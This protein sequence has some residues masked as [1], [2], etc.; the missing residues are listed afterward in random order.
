MKRYE[1]SLSELHETNRPQPMNILLLIE[2]SFSLSVGD[3]FSTKVHAHL[4]VCQFSELKRKRHTFKR[5]NASNLCSGDSFSGGCEHRFFAARCLNNTCSFKFKVFK[6]P[7]LIWEATILVPHSCPFEEISSPF[8]YLLHMFSDIGL[9][10]DTSVI[11]SVNFR[12]LQWHLNLT[13]ETTTK[14]IPAGVKSAA[15]IHPSCKER[16]TKF[17]DTRSI[18]Q[19]IA[20]AWALCRIVQE[21]P[22]GDCI[23]RIKLCQ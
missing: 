12:S 6:R 9:P 23:I 16:C 21:E 11:Y 1:E 2:L 19:L 4:S 20:V 18:C 3:C 13:S 14:L 22:R 8:A 10:L 15:L 5:L 7:N 17:D